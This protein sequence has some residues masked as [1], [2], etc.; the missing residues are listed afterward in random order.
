ML[1]VFYAGCMMRKEAETA[2]PTRSDTIGSM[3]KLFFFLLKER[4][5]LLKG[6]SWER[7]F[8]RALSEVTKHSREFFGFRVPSLQCLPFHDEMPSGD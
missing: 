8:V 3:K 7:G 1:G 6:T 5:L 4:E 2:V